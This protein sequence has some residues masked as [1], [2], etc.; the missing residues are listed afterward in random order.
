MIAEEDDDDLKEFA[1][2]TPLKDKP[3][4]VR[5]KLAGEVLHALPEAPA[6]VLNDLIAGVS[7]DNAGDRVYSAPNLIRFM[8]G[9]LRERE[10]L[11]ATEAIERGND[12]EPDE[13]GFVWVPTDDVRVFNRIVYSKTHIVPIDELGD[14]AIWVAERLANRPTLPSARSGRGR[15]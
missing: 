15:S 5:F 13:D 4:F 2:R 6:G 12:A 8:Q 9:V 1:P 14:M 10:P 11:T 3:K 7:L